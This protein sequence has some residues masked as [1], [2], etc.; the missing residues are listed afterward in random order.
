MKTTFF[1]Y[2]DQ[3][4]KDYPAYSGEIIASSKTHYLVKDLTSKL[5]KEYKEYSTNDG[6][7]KE[8]IKY[9]Y[10]VIP[11]SEYF[12]ELYYTRSFEQGLIYMINKISIEEESD[13]HFHI[14][15]TV[16]NQKYVD[17]IIISKQEETVLDLSDLST[18][19]IESKTFFNRA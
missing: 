8:H 13:I 4:L 1:D 17:N 18:C 14:P 15:N 6:I 12:Y 5:P 3:K 16:F 10:V 2:R 9:E 11:K 7:Y 19:G